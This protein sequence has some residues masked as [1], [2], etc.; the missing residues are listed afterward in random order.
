MD[1]FICDRC[2]SVFGS[3]K[4]QA[5]T[6]HKT[7][8]ASPRGKLYPEDSLCQV[9]LRDPEISSENLERKTVG[10]SHKSERLGANFEE[11]ES[12]S[13]GALDVISRLPIST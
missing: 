5:G 2:D 13:N 9:S 3:D 7:C 10:S 6:K 8:N 1:R 4:A 11:V 12:R